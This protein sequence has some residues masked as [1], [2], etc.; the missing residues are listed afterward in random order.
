MKITFMLTWADA[1]GGTE[2]AIYTQAEHLAADHDVE[3]VSV[4]R[5]SAERFFEVGGGVPVRYLVDETG[6]VP[7]PVRDCDLDDE[8]CRTLA[9]SPS[10]LIDPRW[11]KAFNR[12]SD[13]EIERELRALDTDVLVSTSP[14]LMAVTTTLPPARVLTVHQEHRPSQIR[15]GTGEPLFRYAPRLDALVVLTERTREW[16]EETLTDCAPRL[17][18]IVNAVP[19][20]FRPRSSLT[21]KSVTMARRLVP[22]KQVDHAI[23][24][25]AQV[26]EVHPDWVLRVFGDGPQ[27]TRLRRLVSALGLH[28][29]VQLLGP[30]GRMAEEWAKSSIALL[31]SRDGEAF[32]LVLTEAF[33]A[34]VP[35]V[36]YDCQ[37]GPA[38]IITHG[39]NGFLVAQDDI[40]GLAAALIKLIGDPRMLREFGAAALASA[41]Q[42]DIDRVM[43]DWER[44]YADLLDGR[45]DADR[46]A[47]KADRLAAWT[48]RTGGSGFAPAVPP[49]VPPLSGEAGRREHR[50]QSDQAG[51][52]RFGGRLCR[53]TDDLMPAEVTRANLEIVTGPLDRAGVAYQLLRDQGVRHRVVVRAGQRTAA[54]EALTGAYADDAVYAEPLRA[55]GRAAAGTLVA[56]IE[57]AV[58]LAGL[59]VFQPVVTSSRTLSYGPAYGCDLE[60]WTEDDD[61]SSTTRGGPTPHTPRADSVGILVPTRRTLL[62]DT[63][64]AAAMTPGRV[65]IG[66]REYPSVAALDATLVADVAFPVDVVYTWVDG[67]DPDWRSRRNE[68]FAAMGRP[69]VDAAGSDARF[70]SRDELRYSLRSLEMFAPWVRTIH[71][72]TDDQVPA[73]LD[74]SHPKIRIVDHR[75]IFGDRGLLPTFNSHAIESQLHHIDG[76]SDQFLYFN[77]DVFLG[78]PV[79]AERFFHSSGTAR[80]FQSPTSVPLTPVSPE[81]DFNF[82]AGKN[83]RRLIEEAFGHTLTHAFLHTPHALRRDVLADIAER[84]PAE[85]ATTAASQVRAHTDIAIP[86]SLHHYVGFFTG[87]S[88]PGEI[89]STYVNV[90][91][92]TQ[93]PRLTQILT[94]RQYEVICLND[95]HHGD[96]SPEEQGQVVFA[97]LESYFPVASV[98]EKGSPR[99]LAK[100]MQ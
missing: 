74:T 61:E 76:L 86:S 32:P 62:G 25:F 28:D 70:R 94:Q 34:G 50:L 37:T 39:E 6:P 22:D 67:D 8:L 68:A 82:S 9:G 64:P 81:D 89:K 52:V 100:L 16:F 91:D 73:W 84:F 35:A 20:G 44:L 26:A 18:V 23:R 80:H 65:R 1:M 88:V 78:S 21:G 97:F 14:A 55:G 63:V 79:T 83:N 40:D 3:I 77:D 43:G 41:G 4:F 48:T 49:P 54:I 45:D 53:V 38:E 11:E 75:E 66:D 92:A 71:L 56:E 36:S 7:R 69:P 19:A 98:F 27:L 13:L 57:D 46:G 30:T 87:R 93:H 58:D 12:L 85:V 51:L 15:G 90:G 10:R 59:R 72:V 47:V 60:F 42:Y 29:Q 33:A 5:T 2:R 31:T 95:T 99:N 24:A 17:E 96:L